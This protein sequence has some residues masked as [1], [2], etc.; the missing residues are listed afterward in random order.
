VTLDE[1]EQLGFSAEVVEAIELLTRTR[2]ISYAD[3]IVR[4]KGNS[5]AR[6]VKLADLQDNGALWR[7][8]YRASQ[9][10][11]DLNQAGRYILSYQFL[12]DRID[13]SEYLRLMKPL[14]SQ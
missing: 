14:L 2:E 8:L 5:L 4:L 9:P 13:Q 6:Q 12:E 10:E 11:K 3:Y 7:A 1:L